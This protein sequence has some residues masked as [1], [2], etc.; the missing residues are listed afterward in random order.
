MA[1][2]PGWT[3]IVLAVISITM[4]IL[5]LSIK[6]SAV[7]QVYPNYDFKNEVNSIRVPMLP[8]G[9]RLPCE[10]GGWVTTPKGS[11]VYIDPKAPYSIEYIDGRK[12]DRKP[13][14][15]VFDKPR[16]ANR[17]FRLYGEGYA[18]VDIARNVY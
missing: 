4:I 15:P 18:D 7:E 6:P 3:W 12:F 16:P 10:A 5:A 11:E 9:K 14:Q 13:K 17:I 8:P 2:A 1:K